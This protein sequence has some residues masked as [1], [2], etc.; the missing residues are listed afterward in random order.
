[1][2]LIERDLNGGGQWGAGRFSDHTEKTLDRL[3]EDR[4]GL[5]ALLQEKGIIPGAASISIGE[6]YR[7]YT[8]AA[9]AEGQSARTFRTK[10][11]TFKHVFQYW[12]RDRDAATLTGQDAQSYIN[13]LTTQAPVRGRD[14]RGYSPATKAADIKVLRAVWNWARKAGLLANAPFSEVVRGGFVNVERGFYVDGDTSR[15]V[16]DACPSQEWRALFAL[17]RYGG[18]RSRE[19][20]ILRWRDVDLEKGFMTVRSPKTERVGKGARV[21]PIFPQLRR[22]LDAWKQEVET[23]GLIVDA[24][25]RVISRYSP[26]SNVGT[27]LKKIILKAGAEPWPRLLQNLRASA[28]TDIIQ[29]YKPAEESAWLGHSPLVSL[30]HYQRTTQDAFNAALTDETL[31]G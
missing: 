15:R 31:F 30:Q 11:T 12:G 6:L 24:D 18:L 27:S 8:E 23:S 4:P 16:L 20:L 3:R 22:E 28:T 9:K 21:T 13:W 19:A 14:K 26:D 2:T 10:E 5:F 17:Y 25:A 1:M 29:R 7:R